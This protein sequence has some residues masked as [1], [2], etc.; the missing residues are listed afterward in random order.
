MLKLQPVLHG[1]LK[2]AQISAATLYKRLSQNT[3]GYKGFSEHSFIRPKWDMASSIMPSL[4]HL[5]SFPLLLQLTVVRSC[6]APHSVSSAWWCQTSRNHV[7][8]V[9]RTSL[10]QV[11]QTLVVLYLSHCN[12]SPDKM[13]TSIST[14]FKWLLKSFM[15][16]NVLIL[17]A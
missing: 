16:A 12:L 3:W 6:S 8:P 1:S 11:S 2:T 15:W 5:P 10:A 14:P 7:H 4:L 9:M 13:T 17:G